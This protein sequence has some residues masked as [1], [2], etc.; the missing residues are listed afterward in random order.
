[1]PGQPEHPPEKRKDASSVEGWY[2]LTGLGIE[3]IAA[4][5]L[6]LGLGYLIDR[7][8]NT[9]PWFFLIG[10]GLGFT[11]GLFILIRAAGKVFKD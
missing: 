6:G 9:A 5:L 3:F 1:M 7:A 10:G 11:A 2:R 4:V 8:A